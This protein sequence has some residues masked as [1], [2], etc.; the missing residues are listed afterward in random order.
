MQDLE[1]HENSLSGTLP[2]EYGSLSNLQELRLDDNE[3]DSPA[4]R[5]SSIRQVC[6]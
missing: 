5:F 1:L 2:S 6:P 4:S 3:R